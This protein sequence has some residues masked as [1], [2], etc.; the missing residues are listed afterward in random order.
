MFFRSLITGVSVN[1]G[2][3][4]SGL[5]A[6]RP[7]GAIARVCRVIAARC[8]DCRLTIDASNTAAAA[9]IGPLAARSTRVQAL[10]YVRGSPLYPFP[11]KGTYPCSGYE[12]GARSPER[13]GLIS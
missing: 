9:T 12:W 1:H 6:V 4:V 13:N 8:R 2:V 7:P 10:P 5:L 11:L 3:S